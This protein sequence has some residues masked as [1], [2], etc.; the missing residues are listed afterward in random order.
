MGGS[1]HEQPFMATHYHT[2]SIFECWVQDGSDFGVK[3]VLL[4]RHGILYRGKVEKVQ[5]FT[6]TEHKN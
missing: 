2:I 5:R 1:V 6:D 4:W 3:V